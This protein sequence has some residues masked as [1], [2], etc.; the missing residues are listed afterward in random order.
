MVAFK[1]IN[2]KNKGVTIYFKDWH[3]ELPAYDS[4]KEVCINIIGIPPIWCTWP[5]ISQIASSLGVIV[6]IDWHEIFRSF[7]EVVRVQVAVREPQLIPK[8]RLFEFQQELHLLNFE[9]D[10]DTTIES[11]NHKPSDGPPGPSAGPGGFGNADKDGEGDNNS[12]DDLLG[13]EME[14]DANSQ[15]AKKTTPAP[16][17]AKTKTGGPLPPTPVG[18]SNLISSNI[19]GDPVTKSYLDP[20]KKPHYEG[21]GNSLL[22]N[23][24]AVKDDPS[25]LGP[26]SLAP[27]S[28][29][30]SCPAPRPQVH[31]P[32]K[33]K[34]GPVVATRM[35]NRIVRDGKNSIAKAQEIKRVQNLEVTRG[36][37]SVVSKNSF[38]CLDNDLL[39]HNPELPGLKLGADTSSCNNTI[40]IIKQIE[41]KRLS[42][43]HQDNPEFSPS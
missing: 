8:D 22:V 19:Q 11:P 33:G 39:L 31:R 18:Q 20:A 14:K 28:T 17:G 27:S 42:N 26:S 5:V 32:G 38:A 41:L 15:M 30:L 29:T 10:E 3:G 37:T 13:E 21:C 16:S 9:V 24:E 6:N 12:D 4:L 40:E 2:L 7:Y 34:W 23:F 43:F 25:D 35:S 36:N 1:F